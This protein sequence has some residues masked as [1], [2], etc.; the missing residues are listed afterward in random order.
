MII[1]HEINFSLKIRQLVEAIYLAMDIGIISLISVKVMFLLD[2]YFLKNSEKKSFWLLIIFLIFEQHK[3]MAAKYNLEL[4]MR[5]NFKKN[6][7][8]MKVVELNP[9]PRNQNV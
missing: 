6:I 3:R 5:E 4:S 7:I 8:I 2:A 1:I 9:F